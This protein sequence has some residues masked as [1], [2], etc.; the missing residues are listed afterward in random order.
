MLTGSML[1]KIITVFTA[2]GMSLLLG[3]VDYYN[4]FNPQQSYPTANNYQTKENKSITKM[5]FGQTKD[6]KNVYLYTLTNT[7]GLVAK[8]TNYGATLTE[9]HLPD[10]SGEL[11]DDTQHF[12]DSVNQPNF[13]SV[14][15]NPGETYR[16]LMV[17]KFYTKQNN[18]G[19]I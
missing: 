5:E 1:L 13:P 9:L 11:D 8:I 3:N 17:Y 15:L 12:P 6:G 10:K 2:M 19:K 4:R 16:H 7:N 14:I 18:L